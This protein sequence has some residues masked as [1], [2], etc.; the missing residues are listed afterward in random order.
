[1][2][3]P[4]KKRLPAILL[5]WLPALVGLWAYTATRDWA[6]SW[7]QVEMGHHLTWPPRAKRGPKPEAIQMAGDVLGAGIH[8]LELAL[9]AVAALAVVVIVNRTRHRRR[10]RRAMDRWELRL[11]RDDLANPYH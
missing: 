3:A 6:H 9:A 4:P 7:R 8:I 10:R 5:I 2:R 11:G 1:M